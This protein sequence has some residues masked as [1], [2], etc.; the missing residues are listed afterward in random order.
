MPHEA[1]LRVDDRDIHS[2]PLPVVAGVRPRVDFAKHTFT[3]D[4]EVHSIPLPDE[5]GVR[6]YVDFSMRMLRSEPARYA[7][8]GEAPHRG[9]GRPRRR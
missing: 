1:V 3:H 8:A 4:R 5:W 2:I 7:V 9:G 6:T